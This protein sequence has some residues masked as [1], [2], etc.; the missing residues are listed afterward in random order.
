[1]VPTSIYRHQNPTNP[2]FF[3]NKPLCSTGGMARFLS[4][5]CL[6]RVA[7]KRSELNEASPN[8][9]PRFK[10]LSPKIYLP[11]TRLFT[12]LN[13]PGIS[14]NKGVDRRA[15]EWQKHYVLTTTKV[16]YYFDSP[17]K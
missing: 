8:K 11:S 1:M 15:T 5:A 2:T 13:E 9:L 7:N 6:K 16:V 12:Q 4:K 3:Y 14:S 10:F 17:T